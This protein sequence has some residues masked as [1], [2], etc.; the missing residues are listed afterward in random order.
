MFTNYI[1]NGFVH[2]SLVD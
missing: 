1:V 2:S